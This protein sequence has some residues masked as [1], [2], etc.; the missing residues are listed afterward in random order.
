M[1]VHVIAICGCPGSGKSTLA[2]KLAEQLNA[3]QLDMDDYQQFTNMTPAGLAQW[4]AEGADFN[5]LDLGDFIQRLESTKQHALEQ[6][7]P[8]II[9]ESHFGRAHAKTCAYFDQVFWLDAPADLALA[10]NL[11]AL[12]IGAAELSDFLHHYITRLQPLLALQRLRLSETSDVHLD[13][14]LPIDR[15]AAEVTQ[16]IS[17]SHMR[18]MAAQHYLKIDAYLA[19][20]AAACALACACRHKLLNP[21]HHPLPRT[22]WQGLC[23]THANLSAEGAE[24]LLSL[25]MANDVV[26]AQGNALVLAPAFAPL[27]AYTDLIQTKVRFAQLLAPDVTQRFAQWL[28]DGEEFM[29]GSQ[30]FSLFDYHTATQTDFE[31]VRKSREWMQLVSTYTRYEAQVFLAYFD[32]SNITRMLDIGGNSGE[33]LRQLCLAKPT[34]I[35]SVADLPGVCA[36]ALQYQQ[37]QAGM[38]QVRH[39]PGDART[40]PIPINQDCVSFKSFLHDWPEDQLDTWLKVAANSLLPGGRIVIFERISGPL[41]G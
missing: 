35:G 24:L 18:Q 26:R 2:T 13:A 39:I 15:L 20:S 30:L 36:A 32:M 23:Q 1:T 37:G 28:G 3:I 22:Q 34:L 14:S 4:V 40:D 9:V 16:H 17:A 6:G 27:M 38:T 12:D 29:A 31:S 10:R 5:V 25:L 11:K 7:Q 33:F 21:L 8:L 19:Q 41:T